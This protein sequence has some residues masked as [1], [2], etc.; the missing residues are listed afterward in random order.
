[1]FGPDPAGWIVHGVT[2]GPGTPR[3]LSYRLVVAQARAKMPSA[4]PHMLRH[5]FASLALEAGASLEEVRVLLGHGTISMTARYLHAGAD[6]VRGAIERLAA[7]A[8]D[9]HEADTTRAKR[10][11]RLVSA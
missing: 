8:D 3:T 10:G 11:P 1:M 7:Q 9:W 5:T 2:G 6:S 4:G